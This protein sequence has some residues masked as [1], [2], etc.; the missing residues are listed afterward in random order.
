MNTS[1]QRRLRILL[2]TGLTNSRRITGALSKGWVALAILAALFPLTAG[3]GLPLT[4]RIGPVIPFSALDA[5]FARCLVRSAVPL[6]A[7]GGVLIQPV[8]L[9]DLFMALTR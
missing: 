9:E 7:A 5:G 2:V 3:A 6:P 4:P 1:I 8:N